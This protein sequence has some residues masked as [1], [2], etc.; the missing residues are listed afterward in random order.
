MSG[1]YLRNEIFTEIWKY[2][3]VSLNFAHCNIDI[4]ADDCVWCLFKKFTSNIRSFRSLV[5][6]GFLSLQKFKAMIAIPD[7]RAMFSKPEI[8]AA[9]FRL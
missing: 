1:I 8:D 7:K 9:P 2:R 3:L 6:Q 5:L 4:S